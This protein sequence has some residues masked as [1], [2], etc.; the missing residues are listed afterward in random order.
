MEQQNFTELSQFLVLAECGS[1]VKAADR[2]GI[3]SSA[4]SHSI[5]RLEDRLGIRLFNRTTRS[6]TLT[7]AGLQLREELEPLFSSINDKLESISEFL[8]EPVGTVRLNVSIDVAENIIYPRL[9]QLLIDYPRI[10]VDITIDN[11]FV[12]IVSQGYDMGVRIGRDI[13]EGFIA[14]QIS[15]KIR[16][17][18][19]ASKSYL[20]KHPMPKSIADLDQHNTI[21]FRLDNNRNQAPWF[22]N[23]NGKM[24]EYIPK[25]QFIVSQSSDIVRKAIVDGLGIGVIY[26]R[27]LAKEIAS[28]EVVE[29]L[30]ECS[31]SFEPLFLYYSSR[32]GNTTAFKMVVEALRQY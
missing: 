3:S 1:F 31:M 12:D 9:K 28:G 21:G 22:L 2:L 29:I 24:V 30:P 10:K 19:V 6:V 5:K 7:E 16:N 8:D 13:G 26:E 25:S 23:D 4:V 20:E 14:V 15:D 27:G 32:K 17:K 18:L 11:S